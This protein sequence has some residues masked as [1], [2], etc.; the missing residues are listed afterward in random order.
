MMSRPLSERV[1]DP[2]YWAE[3]AA[4]FALGAVAAAVVAI[5][6][7]VVGGV[8]A[9]LWLGAVREYEQLPVASWGDLIID[10]VATVTGGLVV[11]LALFVFG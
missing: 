9:A 4:H 6:L 2:I 1:R 7:A 11:G 10:L 8:C 3:Q 5:P